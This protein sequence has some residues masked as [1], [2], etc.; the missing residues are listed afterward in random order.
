MS[1][2]LGKGRACVHCGGTDAADVAATNLCHGYTRSRTRKAGHFVPPIDEYSRITN[3]GDRSSR[4]ALYHLANWFRDE[5]G[6]DRQAEVAVEARAHIAVR[7]TRLN[8]ENHQPAERLLAI[9][10]VIALARGNIAVQMLE[11]STADA[12]LPRSARTSMKPWGSQIPI[13]I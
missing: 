10:G 2:A 9:T 4:A 13:S 6:G 12:V 7:G 11:K 1:K 8:S 3:M 5:R